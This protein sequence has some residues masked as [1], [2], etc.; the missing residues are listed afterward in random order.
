[1]GTKFQYTR[2]TSEPREIEYIWIC[3]HLPLLVE[4]VVTL[5]H[6]IPNVYHR[7]YQM[8]YSDWHY[9]YHKSTQRKQ[10]QSKTL[11]VEILHSTPALTD[12]RVAKNYHNWLY[13][14]STPAGWL[15]CEQHKRKNKRVSST[16]PMLS[17]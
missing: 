5:G 16:Q 3:C 10:N 9:L 2:S 14:E 6:N 1:M 17:S 8:C 12:E 4:M 15:P 13:S 7:R 11:P